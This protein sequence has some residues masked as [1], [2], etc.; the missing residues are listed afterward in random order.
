MLEEEK[1]SPTDTWLDEESILIGILEGIS[2]A[3]SMNV[4]HR[5]IKPQNILLDFDLE[6]ENKKLFPSICDF[7]A[8]KIYDGGEIKKSA[9]TVVDFRTKMYRPE[10]SEN[11]DI[12][13]QYQETWD[14][15][16]WAL[17][18]I[19]TLSNKFLDT[20]EQALEVLNTELAPSMDSKIVN[21]IKK[22]M[23][24]DPTKRP[25]DIKK[26]K[27]QLIALTEDRKKRLQ[28]QE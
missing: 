25:K 16:A 28:W 3:H 17:L 23:A 14:L 27:D 1:E 18:A 19:E 15:F 20:W 8:A 22:A 12:E 13:L 6:R 10:F 24:K 21:L 5:D 9:H 4:L 7:G 2:Y 11:G 26:F